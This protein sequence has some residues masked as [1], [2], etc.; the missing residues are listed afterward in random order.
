M[1]KDLFK[2][3]YDLIDALDPIIDSF[4]TGDNDPRVECEKELDEAASDWEQQKTELRSE[5]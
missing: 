2:D 5:L 1:D 4:G 3:M